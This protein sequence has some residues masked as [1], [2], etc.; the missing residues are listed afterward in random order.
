MRHIAYCCAQ[1]WRRMA[2]MIKLKAALSKVASA[3]G[4][5][6]EEEEEE[7]RENEKKEEETDPS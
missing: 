3:E 5:E 1:V 2:D 7:R 4:E 6:E